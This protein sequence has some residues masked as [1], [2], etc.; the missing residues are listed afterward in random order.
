MIILSIFKDNC[1]SVKA[2]D[3]SYLLSF[4]N[5]RFLNFDIDTFLKLLF[6]FILALSASDTP[7]GF[8]N[9]GIHSCFLKYLYLVLNWHINP[10][11][12]KN[13]SVLQKCQY[14]LMMPSLTY[15]ILNWINLRFYTFKPL[16]TNNTKN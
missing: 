1:K 16:K 15:T 9:L 13:L 10:V 4:N 6:I 5:D 3:I 14:I 7:I 11:R 2:I 12:K 8:F